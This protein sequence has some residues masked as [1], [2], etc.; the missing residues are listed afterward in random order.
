MWIIEG[1]NVFSIVV[2]RV[3]GY[4]DGFAATI[5]EIYFNRETGRE[6]I[7]NKDITTKVNIFISE[8]HAIVLRERFQFMRFD[9]FVKKYCLALK[10][11]KIFLQAYLFPSR[12]KRLVGRFTGASRS[13]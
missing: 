2:A 8:N 7:R 5:R 13:D 9:E 3:F 12:R 6:V 4:F 11:N 1:I 10:L